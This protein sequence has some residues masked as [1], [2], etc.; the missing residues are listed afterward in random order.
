MKRHNMLITIFGLLFSLPVG[1][2]GNSHQDQFEH[3]NTLYKKGLFDEAM[4]LYEQIPN[5]SARVNYNL[6]NCAYKLEKYGWALLYWRRAERT[7]GFFNRNELIENISLLKKKLN[8]TSEQGPPIIKKIKQL[9]L[10]WTYAIPLLVLQLLFL[11]LWFFLFGYIRFLYKKRKNGAILLLFALIALFGILL[12]LRYSLEARR[13]AIVVSQQSS[14]LS[15]PGETFQTL[16]QLDPASEVIIKKETT[17]YY[18][19]KAQ[20]KVGWIDKKHVMEVLL[21]KKT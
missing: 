11:L 4:K 6:G 14:L 7:W 19:I 15:G 13:D 3:A 5:K 2:S 20:Q 12:T 21:W 16:I 10:S 1:L 9:V 18:K 8:L 17:G